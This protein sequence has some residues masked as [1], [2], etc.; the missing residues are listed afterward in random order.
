MIYNV[1]IKQVA[2]DLKNQLFL[3]FKH[4]KHY[5]ELHCFQHLKKRV[6]IV[7]VFA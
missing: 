5:V 7:Y 3:N 4:L 1:S 2:E 6:L